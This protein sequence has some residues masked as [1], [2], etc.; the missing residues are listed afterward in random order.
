MT[1]YTSV[2]L[3]MTLHQLFSANDC[4]ATNLSSDSL[5]MTPRTNIT[6]SNQLLE[7]P[8][9]WPISSSSSGPAVCRPNSPGNYR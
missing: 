7:S 6:V 3:A 8:A 2:S 4:L 1:R 5:P 9:N